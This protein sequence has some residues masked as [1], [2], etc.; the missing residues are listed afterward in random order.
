MDNSWL[1][2]PSSSSSSDK[3]DRLKHHHKH[4][5]ASVQKMRDHTNKTKPS[6]GRSTT[7]SNRDTDTTSSGH[8]SPIPNPSSNAHPGRHPQ[9]IVQVKA[10][11]LSDYQTVRS[12]YSRT[13]YRAY[14][15]ANCS[16]CYDETVL[17]YISKI[18]EKVKS[19]E[20]AHFLD[21][22][23]I[24]SIIGFLATLK[25]AC[26]TNRIP[27]G[28]EVWVL[29]FFL[30]NAPATLLNSH[31]FAATNIP[32]VVAFVNTVEPMTQKKF[33]CPYLE[34]IYYLLKKFANDQAT[35]KMDFA[36][37]R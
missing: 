10:Q 27:E 1:L 19:L 17:S 33:L 20:R 23:N 24:I 16:F 18:V 13:I 9:P 15:L 3:S 32:P 5:K 12:H 28:A 21:L 14:R 11:A 29:P 6:D 2:S 37:L 31:I 36:F 4:R 8:D 7:S 22:S 34:L 26:D 25:L 35:S 30:K